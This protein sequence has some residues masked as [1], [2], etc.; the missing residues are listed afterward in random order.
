MKG[1]K[2]KELPLCIFFFFYWCYNPLWVLA[3]SVV[4]FFSTLSLI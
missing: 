2:Y 4:F 1:L 3:F